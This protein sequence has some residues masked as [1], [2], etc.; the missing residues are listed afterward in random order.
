M[1][2]EEAETESRLLWD[3]QRPVLQKSSTDSFVMAVPRPLG[4]LTHL[5]SAS[6]GVGGEDGG[7]LWISLICCE[8]QCVNDTL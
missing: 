2:G 7:G 4:Q 5:R 3:D 6:R 8:Y 1:S